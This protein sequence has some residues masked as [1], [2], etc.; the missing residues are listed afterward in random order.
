MG[1]KATKSPF[2]GS[3]VPVLGN[4]S[5]KQISF[6]YPGLD[7]KTVHLPDKTVDFGTAVKNDDV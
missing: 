6:E 4:K 1:T 7:I 5:K 2:L 3:G